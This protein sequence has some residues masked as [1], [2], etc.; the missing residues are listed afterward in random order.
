MDDHLTAV[1]RVYGP[2]T[3]DLYDILDQTL[4][5]RG[6][7]S[8]LSL[9]IDRT[10]VES[11]ILDVGC[12]DASH[13]IELVKATGARG[14]GID[15]VPRLV[16]Q[17]RAAVAKRNLAARI[18]VVEAQMMS[19][20]FPDSSFD[21]VWCRDVLELVANLRAGL[22]EV[23]RVLR[24]DGEVIVFTVVATDRLEPAD[25]A[26]LAQNL[27]V[28]PENL[29]EAR[30][31]ALFAQAGLTIVAK[32]EIGTEWREYAEERTKPV[33]RDLLRLARLRR[34]QDEIRQRAGQDIYA[35][36]EANLHWS[37]FQFLGKLL[38][39]VYQLRKTT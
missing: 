16:E 22:D 30:I 13:L 14:I 25:A 24:V 11:V 21:V 29:V 34:G 2:E 8:L 1:S 26:M 15:P 10:D 31:E 4:N 36:I 19:I 28:V 17:A 5:P 39:V 3:W 37:V 7:D 38:P 35:H 18:E 27:T 33:S 20:P 23:A 32:D 6:P 12:R 9:A